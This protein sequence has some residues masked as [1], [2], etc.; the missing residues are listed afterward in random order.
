MAPDVHYGSPA[1][2]QK[3]AIM[4][5]LVPLLAEVAEKKLLC[6][7]SVRVGVKTLLASCWS[8]DR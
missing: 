4:E 8:S 5:K 6:R 3:V 7:M 2:G 1:D